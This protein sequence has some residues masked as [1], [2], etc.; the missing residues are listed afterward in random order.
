MEVRFYKD[1][2]GTVYGFQVSG[3]SDYSPEGNDVLCSAVSALTITTVNA[4]ETFTD[5]PVRIEAVNE[6]EGFLHFELKSVSEKSKL[7]LDSLI[8][9][10]K[11][12]ER[13]YDRYLSVIEEEQK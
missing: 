3:H 9:G 10:I 6:E 13:S 2:K 12:I 4:I 1:S 8:L 7:L 5:D 11:D